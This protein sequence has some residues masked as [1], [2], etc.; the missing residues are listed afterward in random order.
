MLSPHSPAHLISL[1]VFLFSGVCW[2][3][4]IVVVTTKDRIVLA[5]DS[6]EVSIGSIVY[7]PKSVNKIVVLNDTT[8]IAVTGLSKCNIA[9]NGK[10]VFQY[11]TDRIVD[12]IKDSFSSNASISVI[13]G[14]IVNKMKASMNRLVPYLRDGAVDPKQAAKGPSF[15]DFII[16]G[17]KSGVPVT[18]RVTINFDWN[19]RKIS[20]PIVSSENSSP[21]RPHQVCFTG[22][23]AI[24]QL[25]VPNSPEQLAAFSRYP[26]AIKGLTFRG[27]NSSNALNAAADLVRLECEFDPKFVGLPIHIVTLTR[28]KK[29]VITTLA[30]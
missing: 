12:Q 19:L 29:P 10:V 25:R 4:T 3:T 17:Y 22:C 8:A 18:D 1:L 24:D 6:K 16:V 14:I 7:G 11:D 13:E 20:G 5:S 23:N 28:D 15:V 30:K 9:A 27:L 21:D 26:D 2:S